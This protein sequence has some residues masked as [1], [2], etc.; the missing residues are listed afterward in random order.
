MSELGFKQSQLP[1]LP[2]HDVWVA[3]YKQLL[4][5]EA[6]PKT[7]MQSEAVGTFAG[8]VLFLNMSE[9]GEIISG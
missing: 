1:T 8:E 4:A 7:D 2:D 3:K 9:N 5:E 6:Q